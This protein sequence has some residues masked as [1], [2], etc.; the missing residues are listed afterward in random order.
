MVANDTP[1]AFTD[2]D[3]DRLRDDDNISCPV[4]EHPV[5]CRCRL[6]VLLARLDAAERAMMACQADFCCNTREYTLWRHSAGKFI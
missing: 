5:G 3:L 2:E 6:K 4:S 1:T